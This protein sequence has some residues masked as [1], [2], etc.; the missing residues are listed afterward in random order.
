MFRLETSSFQTFAERVD[1]EI[2][3]EASASL[4]VIEEHLNVGALAKLEMSFFSICQHCIAL[5]L[6][7]LRGCISKRSR[8][9]V[10]QCPV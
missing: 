4:S 1:R 8:Y 6:S 10:F 9:A 3:C 5:S 7:A 2:L